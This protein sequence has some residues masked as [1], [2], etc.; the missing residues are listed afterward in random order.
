MR[1]PGY[2]D[3]FVPAVPD[4]ILVDRTDLVGDPVF[5]AL[6]L[7][8]TGGSDSAATAFDVD[9]ADMSALYEDLNDQDRWPVLTLPVRGGHRVHLVWCNFPDD[10]GHDYLLSPADN[11]RAVPLAHISGNFHG[12]GLSWD[13]LVATSQQPD[14]V[15]SAAARMLLLLPASG[16]TAAPPTA[17][18]LVAAALTAVGAKRHQRAVATELLSHRNRWTPANWHTTG[19]VSWCSGWYT[20]RTR[21]N[22]DVRLFTTAFS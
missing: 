5:W 18:D 2:V 17:P 6:F 19:G 16:D 21:D 12:P 10:S 3:G 20:Y 22:P 9:P 1:I 4:D 15:L 11:R 8:L 14:P 7:M 13:E